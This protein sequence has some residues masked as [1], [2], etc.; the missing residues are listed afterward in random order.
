MLGFV[1]SALQGVLLCS[2]WWTSINAN[3]DSRDLIPWGWQCESGRCV[4]KYS[5]VD[6][7]LVTLN[8]CKLTCGRAGALWPLPTTSSVG[9]EVALFLPDNISFQ[10][11]CQSEV[12]NL[13]EEAFAIFKDNLQRYHPGY[14]NGDAPWLGPWN[15][16]TEAHLLYVDVTV[17]G[18]NSS[19]T[20]E[21]DESYEL[22][23]T[24]SGDVTTAVIIGSTF[25]GA[26]HALETLSQLV[27]YHETADALMVVKQAA[28]SDAPVFPYRGVLLDTARNYISV[29]SLQRTIDAMA[30]SKLNTLHWHITDT[31]SFPLVVDTVPN[32]NFYG[33]YNPNEVYTPDD[34]IALK[35]YA[36]VRG[37]RLL[38]ELDAP[39]HSGNGW[40]WGEMA[41]LG[42]LAVCVNQEPWQ[43]YCVEPPCGQLN[44]ANHNMYD[45]LSLIYEELV[46]LFSPMDLFHFGGDEINVHCWN[47]TEEIFT[48]MISNGYGVDAA[49]Y[50]SQWATFQEK[51]R[52]LLVAAAEDEGIQGVI[53]TSELTDPDH[54]ESYLNASQYI[55]QIWTTKDDPMIKELLTRGY[56]VIF[57]NYDAWYLDCGMGAW[58]GEGNNWCSPYK[59]W[60]TV[61][62]NN[63]YD[64]AN[65]QT[66]SPHTDL[67]VGG[68]AALWT[69]Q[70]DDATVDSK[71]WPRA[72][73]LA[74]R[75]WSNPS[76]N[77]Y[78]AESAFIQH[79]QRLVKRGIQAERIQPQ[80]C[81]QNE[82]LCYL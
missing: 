60:Q 33:T 63:P 61:Y 79:R 66:G 73:A 28:V 55:I 48:W 30:A 6:S 70:A 43:D 53:W 68:E 23:V 24:T 21:T 45:V 67:I 4:K 72:S 65:S 71:L 7:G 76:T 69:E 36:R 14:S 50:Y 78:A 81:H 32:M 35:E 59:G 62:E 2:F 40:Q 77:W 64:I 9:D 52:Q 15:A 80:W 41:G 1:T 17:T 44:F 22:S 37:V 11:T 3:L 16:T 75:L 29:S 18:V 8:T 49:A 13:L 82:G 51:A 38:P 31:H 46:R 56:R 42:K 47:S 12:C 19:L 5:T 57:S 10:P 34:I 39:A 26:R 25:F 74:E 27:E 54:L 58:V 20:L